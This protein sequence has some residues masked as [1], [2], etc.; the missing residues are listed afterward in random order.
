MNFTKIHGLGNDYLYIN[1]IEYKD[2]INK[3]YIPRLVR[4]MC[5]R[6]FGIGADG[7]IFIED[8]DIADFK[9]SIYNSDGTEAEMCGNGIRGLGKYVYEKELTSDTE[10]TIETLSGIRC[11]KLFV[12]NEE[13]ESVEVNM[14]KVSLD[15]N[16]TNIRTKK[17]PLRLNFNIE[18]KEYKGICASIG[19]PH[20]ITFVNDV[21]KIDVNRVGRIIGNSPCFVNKSNVEFVQI[22]GNRTI[23]MRVWERGVGETFAC[24]TGA[25][26]AVKV[27]N[28]CGFVKESVKV[29][30]KGGELN[31][32]IDENTQE[33]FMKGISTKVFDGS[34]EYIFS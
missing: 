13:V 12:E 14:G 20:F 5:N 9:M 18:N 30:L 33:V 1:C 15:K 6:N 32:K 23:K 4:Y 22:L 31:V 3:E 29:L 34:F 10:L 27:A 19:N 16:I 26:C 28:I 8:S 17:I 25:C 7:V 11:L 2:K 21:D 24:G